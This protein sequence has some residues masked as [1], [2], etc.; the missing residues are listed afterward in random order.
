MLLDDASSTRVEEGPREFV[1]SKQEPN[2]SRRGRGRADVEPLE[3]TSCAPISVVDFHPGSWD[4]SS[5]TNMKFL[6]A[7][8]Q[9]FDQDLSRWRVAG[10]ENP[11]CAKLMLED[12]A[13]VQKTAQHPP[14]PFPVVMT[15]R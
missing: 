4:T 5:I 11:D 9:D 3:N 10:L 1:S 2:R 13:M 14:F 6:F 7:G 8:C 12:T 15:F